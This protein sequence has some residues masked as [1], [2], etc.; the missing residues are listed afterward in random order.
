MDQLLQASSVGVSLNQLISMSTEQYHSLLRGI[1]EVNLIHWLE[2]KKLIA[3]K[4]I[5]RDSG[6]TNLDVLYSIDEENINA[7]ILRIT[8]ESDRFL[9]EK[10][11][12]KLKQSSKYNSHKEKPSS[13]GRYI[14]YR[15]VF[16]L[17]PISSTSVCHYFGISHCDICTYNEIHGQLQSNLPLLPRF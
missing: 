9:F 2:S 15:A 7:I 5:L 11:L 14:G 16:P 17:K 12:L 6:I 1:D 3:I 4:N 8:H 10:E 13:I